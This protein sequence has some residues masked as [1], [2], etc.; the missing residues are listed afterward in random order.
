MF[1]LENNYHIYHQSSQYHHSPFQRNDRIPQ[2]PQQQQ[3]HIIQRRY[4]EQQQQQQ[5]Q[6]NFT[7]VSYSSPSTTT[8]SSSSSSLFSVDNNHLPD[9]E[10]RIDITTNENNNINSNNN[11][12]NN[13]DSYHLQQRSYSPPTPCPSIWST[14]DAKYVPDSHELLQLL[15]PNPVFPPS[16]DTLPPGGCPR[17]PVLQPLSSFEEAI[18]TNLHPAYDSTNATANASQA[19]EIPSCLNS[20]DVSETLPPC[21]SPSVYT[22]GVVSRKIEWVNPY[23]MCT[24]RSWKYL[25]CELNSTQLNFYNIPSSYE[26]KILDFVSK[27]NKSY[28]SQNKSNRMPIN[29]SILTND[30]DHHFYNFVKKQGL[31]EDVSTGS[32]KKGL[33][34]TYSLQYARVGLATDYQK[35]VN[36]LRLRIESEQILLHF[37][38]TQDL[39]D[40]NMLLTVGK[41]IAID[42]NERELPKY[43]TVPRRRRRRGGG[44]G[45]GGGANSRSRG[46]AA[47]GGSRSATHS[48]SAANFSRYNVT[49]DQ[50][51]STRDMI[52]SVSDTNKIKG[53][54]SKLKSK[55]S[56]SRLRSSSS[57]SIPLGIPVA[58]EGSQT[59]MRSNT[60]CSDRS[61]SAATGHNYAY[62]SQQGNSSLSVDRD[63]H[64]PSYSSS[65]ANS[66]EDD[67]DDYDEEFNEVLR[68][69]RN[70]TLALTTMTPQGVDDE[71]EDIQSMSDL[72]LDEDDDDDDDGSGDGN[73]GEED[74]EEDGYREEEG[75]GLGF[76]SLAR[77][78]GVFAIDAPERKVRSRFTGQ[79]DDY[80]WNPR[81]N[82]AYSKRRYYRNC[83][84]CI[85]PLTMED[86]WVY[87][88]M[89]KAT[90]FSP[91]NV[92]YLRAVKYAG[93]NGEVMASSSISIPNSGVSSS[94]ASITSAYR[95][96]G[97]VAINS[98]LTLPDTALTKLPNHFLKEFSV[99]PHG[100]VPR[101]II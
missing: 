91:L 80:K 27:D 49:I 100:L 37:E 42:V 48:S 24:N 86:S 81:P 8:N 46:S 78:R 62:E 94:S 45:G 11:N 47:D 40:W 85:K 65:Y 55:F 7:T 23:E 54:F 77:S 82:E 35:R 64:Q 72:R 20:H 98:S 14:F 97:G 52:K 41:D 57:P 95:K 79:A 9:Q 16:Y 88:P 69:S 36:V 59:R 75:T 51:S 96:N 5:P 28:L 15:E 34:R 17:F 26:E 53:S 29:D 33:V 4:P 32:K 25:I 58:H 83:L 50:F 66:L 13:N 3:Q 63:Y 93:P 38:S 1:T 92:A 30:F 90:P 22:I 89:V 56:S 67:I 31:L 101:E 74:D 21:Y 10:N 44:G 70:E 84:R 61:N 6:Q 12:T 39:I 18:Y 60:N 68:R 87:K 43:R 73:E 19:S 71:Q 2:Q 99:G 76:L